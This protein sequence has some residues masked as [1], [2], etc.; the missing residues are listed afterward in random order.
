MKIILDSADVI[1]MQGNN[2]YP[3]NHDPAFS[4]NNVG[5]ELDKIN[6]HKFE[7]EQQIKY[8]ESELNRLEHIIIDMQE[9]KQKEEEL[10]KNNY[11]LNAV[12][13]KYQFTKLLVTDHQQ[14]KKE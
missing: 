2:E 3:K 11:A 7:M 8:L 4:P 10:R 1:Y 6:K 12:W 9:E 13:E 14:D 5:F